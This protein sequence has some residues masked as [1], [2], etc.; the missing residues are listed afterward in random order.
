MVALPVLGVS[1]DRDC[2]SKLGDSGASSA[3]SRWI[4]N[5]NN[6]PTLMGSRSSRPEPVVAWKV[7]GP[8]LSH[9]NFH[10]AS[11][12][13]RFCISRPDTVFRSKR[14]LDA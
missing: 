3:I 6:E 7:S 12:I 14:T 5:D 1:W 4:A 11:C 13:T 10:G 8:Q 2:I 9:G